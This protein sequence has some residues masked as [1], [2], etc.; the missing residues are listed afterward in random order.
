METGKY[1]AIATTPAEAHV[2]Y[3]RV[4]EGETYLIKPTD[5]P[6]F[7]S[8][9]GYLYCKDGGRE[10]VYDKHL[11]ID[12][13][14]PYVSVRLTD[15]TRGGKREGS[16]R[17]KGKP[18]KTLAYRVPLKHAKKIDKEIRVVINKIVQ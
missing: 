2:H 5:D 14:A 3:T 15:E 10:K 17:P 6:S 16:G 1:I 8:I 4:K 9:S 13:V 11:H 18:T 7:V 12:R